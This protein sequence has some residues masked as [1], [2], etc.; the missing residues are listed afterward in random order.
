MIQI[1]RY[2][3]EGFKA[4]YQ[5]NLKENSNVTL[6]SLLE[7]VPENKYIQSLIIKG[8]D[9]PDEN[10]EYE[11]IFVFLEKPNNKDKEYFLNHLKN[12]DDIPLNSTFIKKAAICY[13]DDGTVYK[14]ENRITIEEAVLRKI[15][16]V[17]IP[18]SELF[19]IKNK[20]KLKI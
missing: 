2:S 13:I 11:G 18:K 20:V 16:T 4:Q 8:F 9:E 17:Y 6:Q 15:N 1:F 14:K 5:S 19:K 3:R 12:I 7:K 10:F